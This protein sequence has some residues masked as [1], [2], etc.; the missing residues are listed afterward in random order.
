[1]VDTSDLAAV[2][3]ARVEAHK[4][5]SGRPRELT[6]RNFLIGVYLVASTGTLHITR[7]APMLNTLPTGTR[8]RLGLTRPGGVT[9][10]QIQRLFSTVTAAVRADGETALDDIFDALCDAT[11]PDEASRTWSLALDSTDIQSW[12]RRRSV[13]SQSAPSD[14]DARWRGNSASKS[15]WKQPLYGYDLTAAVAAPDVVGEDVPLVARRVRLRPATQDV[16]KIGLDAVAAAAVMQGGLGDVVADRAYSRR[17]DGTDF[18]LPVRALGGEPVFALRTDQL[19]VSGTAHGA[20]IIDGSPFS[21]SVPKNLHNI[22][23]PPV[24]APLSAIVAYQQQ[25]AKRAQHALVPH[26][27]RNHNGDADYRCPAAAGKLR[28]PLVP[29]SMT[30]TMATPTALTA[31]KAARAGSVCANATKR[32]TAADIPLAQQDLH[33]TREWYNSWNRRNRVEGYFGNIKDEANESLR[34]GI[35]RVRTQEK[36]GLWLAFAVAAANIRLAEAYR[37]RKATPAPKRKRGRPRK[38]G[39]TQYLPQGLARHVAAANAPPDLAA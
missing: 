33:G 30:P 5:R 22:K 13:R 10:R 23:P 34:R 20:I 3:E 26:G 36:L 1:M 9:E 21:P 6:M 25:V 27:K 7:V 18:A 2:L 15:P 39:L 17:H 11:Q 29:A 16:V 38:S 19:G 14:P 32:F 37:R 31:P 28:C 12:G 35:V 8:R 4:R 24:G